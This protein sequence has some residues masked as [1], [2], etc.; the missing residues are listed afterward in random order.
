MTLKLS[1]KIRA[2]YCEDCVKV[3]IGK[4]VEIICANKH[5]AYELFHFLTGLNNEQLHDKLMEGSEELFAE[6]L[7]FLGEN[8]KLFA[9]YILNEAQGSDLSKH[10][11]IPYSLIRNHVIKPK[12]DDDDDGK[13]D[14]N[15]EN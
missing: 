4:R 7:Y 2:L 9:E 5:R 11:T 6:G 12:D 15:E 3:K 13:D 1:S 10:M 8:L 14:G